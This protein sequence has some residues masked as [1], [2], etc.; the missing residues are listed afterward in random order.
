MVSNKKIQIILKK[1]IWIVK[2]HYY[3][4]IKTKT[5]KSHGKSI[6]FASNT[7]LFRGYGNGY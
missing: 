5:E 4:T 1:S 6:I 2:P 3:P 7:E